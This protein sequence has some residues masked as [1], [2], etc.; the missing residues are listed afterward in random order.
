[1]KI[2]KVLRD[3]VDI[4]KAAIAAIAQ[5]RSSSVM[6]AGAGGVSASSIGTPR[7]N[8]MRRLFARTADRIL[9]QLRPILFRYR[10]YMNR[11]ILEQIARINQGSTAQEGTQGVTFGTTSQLESLQKQL[12]RIEHYALAT[13][14]RFAINCGH[15]RVLVRSQVG[16][17]FCSPADSAQLACLI[18]RGELEAGTRRLIERLIKPG[19]IFV[20]IGA[21]IGLHTLAAA[22]AMQGVGK[23]VAF[24]PYAPTLALLA[25]SV[26]INGFSG[27]VELH[28]AA[29]SSK[30]G[31]QRLHLGKWSGHHSLYSLEENDMSGKD[32]DVAI[33]RLDE[34]IPLHTKIDCIKIDVEGAELEVLEG[35]K[36][37]IKA[38]PDIVL[39]VEFG[40]SHLRRVGI[41]I[42]EWFD[43]FS[44]IDLD[45]QAIDPAVGTLRS[46]DRSTL[47]QF[48]S[49]NLL[50][51]RRGSSIWTRLCEAK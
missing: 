1:M 39:I 8:W 35:A 18:D 44:A 51:A 2:N 23:I 28:G 3:G 48:E 19:M 22:R 11:P 13:A 29:V 45:Y 46:I 12:D 47:S 25:E 20:D 14:Q 50:F 40:P 6:Q 7:M 9:K 24:E 27:I 5:V 30:A 41:G 36:H 31:V 43:R 26:A 42:D 16:F 34:A 10:E 33:V 21:N 15:G 38:N 32:V 37:F 49:I 17:V 4:E